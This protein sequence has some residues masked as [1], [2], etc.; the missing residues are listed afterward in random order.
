MNDPE[1]IQMRNRFLFA[2]LIAVVF[3]IPLLI[4]VFRVYG[5]TSI[6]TRIDRK[7][8]FTILVT[9]KKCDN[10]KMVENIFDQYNVDYSNLNSIT[11]KDY[12]SIMK[13]ME[14]ENKR[15]TFPIIIYVENGKMKANLFDINSREAVTEFLDFHGLI[16]S[17]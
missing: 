14:I 2:V 6:L 16:N 10:C 13:R 4:F 11:N 15:N 9:T 17:K 7:D 3:A 5:N 12:Q 8:T 1:F